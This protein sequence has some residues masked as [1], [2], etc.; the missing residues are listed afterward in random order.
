LPSG[1]GNGIIAEMVRIFEV[2][3]FFKDQFHRE[4]FKKGLIIYFRSQE[5]YAEKVET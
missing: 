4:R 1:N 3:G 2:E 5:Y